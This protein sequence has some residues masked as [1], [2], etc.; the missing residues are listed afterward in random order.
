MTT[1]R[2]LLAG[3]LL[4]GALLGCAT[5]HV[6]T[7]FFV[8]TDPSQANARGAAGTGN[9]YVGIRGTKKTNPGFGFAQTTPDVWAPFDVSIHTGLFD[10]GQ[11]AS[12]DGTRVCLEIDNVGFTVFYDVCA[13]YAASPAGWTVAAFHGAPTTNLPGSFFT[14]SLEIEL[15]AETDGTTLRFH[16]RPWTST[17]WQS[18]AEMPWP[19][20]TGPLEAA[21]GV[22]PILK[23]TLVGFDDPTFASGPPPSAPTG[24][25]EVAAAANDALL[26]G[27]A[28]FQLLD[29]ASPDFPGAAT[30]LGLAGSALGQAQ[31]LLAALPQDKTAK[32]AGKSFAKGAKKLAKAEQ[33]VADQDA[34]G[35]LANLG[36]AGALVEKGVL[37]LVP[38][39]FPT[40]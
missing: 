37:L 24:V 29:G 15:R 8:V 14:E 7:V 10:P 31:T 9:R 23:G 17:K 25:A 27:L 34:D 20:Q 22:S 13:T 26:E 39:P 5:E 40:D 33:Q 36:K 4:W 1:P 32:K 12:A 35:A 6:R 18:V 3:C 21:F 28:A 30:Q 11:M 19:G 16:A 2:A 38:Q